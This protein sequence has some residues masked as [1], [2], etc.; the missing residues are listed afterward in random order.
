[1]QVQN[2]MD[3]WILGNQTPRSVNNWFSEI[4]YCQW[5]ISRSLPP[6]AQFSYNKVDA[7]WNEVAQTHTRQYEQ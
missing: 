1:M 2:Y 3:L 6:I 5:R 4:C 7:T